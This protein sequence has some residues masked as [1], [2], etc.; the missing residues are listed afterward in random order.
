M[1]GQATRDRERGVRHAAAVLSRPALRPL[2]AELARRMGASERPVSQV[3]VTV[4][5]DGRAAI[6]GLLGWTRLPPARVRV[7]TRR[8]AE[9]VGVG[10][11]D[12]RTV[13]ERIVGPVGNRAA[14]REASRSELL[15]AV[16][17][18]T[19]AAAA[20]GPRAQEWAA[21][22]VRSLPGP[23][24]QR[25]AAVVE[26]C[27][28]LSAARPV[29]R[30]L[31]VVAAEATGD[32][33]AFD[34]STPRGALLV[35]CAAVAS[36][37]PVPT[38]AAGRRD[39]LAGAGIVADELSST[40]ATWNLLPG[41]DHP[42][43]V[44]AAQLTAA[45]EPLVWT[46][47]MVRRWPIRRW[48]QRVLVVENPAVLSVAALERFDG[49]VICSSGRPS[50]AVLALVRDA[51]AA[52]ARVDAHADFDQGGFG[53]LSDLVAAGACPWRM[54]AADYLAVADR[55]TVVAPG[56]SRAVST[57]WD[58]DLAV[59]FAELG[60]VVFEEQLLDRLLA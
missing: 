59:R 37:S 48:P 40:V 56:A 15:C 49:T 2:V 21:A 22:K 14:Q 34:L 53:V 33:H 23:V 27:A 45:G 47:S 19:S 3:T 17:E 38:S 18:A 51:V 58:P 60:R 12:L 16:D 43:A 52:G 26:V 20:L 42:L 35:E 24:A 55:S 39:V 32:P 44:T 29:R 54:G 30:P 25:A 46:L 1:T 11:E 4:D 31:A 28:V 9:A 8:V 6:A 13:V 41:G 36:G 10:T 50:T 5:D 57:P 7:R